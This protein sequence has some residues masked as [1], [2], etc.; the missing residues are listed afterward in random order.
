MSEYLDSMWRKD[1]RIYKTVAV[2]QDPAVVI[3]DVECP[4]ERRTLVIGSMM[5]EEY[6]RLTPNESA[7]EA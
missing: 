2:I 1:G 5:Y 6:E 7:V 3:E 4:T